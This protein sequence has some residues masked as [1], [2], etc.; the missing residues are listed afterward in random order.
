MRIASKL[1]ML[2][3]SAAGVFFD[4]PAG[5]GRNQLVFAIDSIALT[6]RLPHP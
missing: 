2:P 1:S 5:S 4:L 3:L 6:S